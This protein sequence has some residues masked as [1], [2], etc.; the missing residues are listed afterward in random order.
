MLDG[1]CLDGRR[2][3]PRVT[4]TCTATP[5]RGKTPAEFDPVTETGTGLMLCENGPCAGV[6]FK[7]VLPQAAPVRFG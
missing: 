2:H 5:L 7:Q 3:R 6:P 1:S 4:R